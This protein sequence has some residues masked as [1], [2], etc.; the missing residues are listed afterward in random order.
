MKVAINGIEL[1]CIAAFLPVRFDATVRS[2][3]LLVNQSAIK[4][5]AQQQ[6]GTYTSGSADDT[7]KGTLATIYD[8]LKNV[9]IEIVS[10]YTHILL[11]QAQ[12]SIVPTQENWT[13]APSKPITIKVTF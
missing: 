5:W 12:L 3:Q 13:M 9:S 11:F 2:F 4:A 10:E 6:Q 7:A 1:E 8:A